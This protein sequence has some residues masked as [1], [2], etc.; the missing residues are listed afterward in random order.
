MEYAF[1]HA[2]QYVLDASASLSSAGVDAIFRL[3][4]S[5]E[6][7]ARGW[8]AEDMTSRALSAVARASATWTKNLRARLAHTEA[9]TYEE[10]GEPGRVLK[11]A[12]IPL[13]AAL[14]AV[15]PNEIAVRMLAA[16]VNPSDLNIIEGKYPVPRELPAVGGNEGVGEVISVGRDAERAFAIGDRVVPN[17]SYAQGTWRREVIDVASSFDVIDRDI[18][19]H[20]AAMLTVNPCTAYRLLEDSDIREGETVVLNAATSG[21]GRALLQIARDRG[22]K[23]IAMCRPRPDEAETEATFEALR[24]AGADVVLPDVEGKMLRLDAKTRELAAKA[25]YGFN[26]VSGYSAQTMLRLL[27]PNASSVMVTY[28]GMSKQPLV[29]PTG[30]FIFKDITLRGFWLTRWLERDAHENAG[31]GRRAM[32]DQVSDLIRRNVVSNPV[33]ALSDVPLRDL[34]TRLLTDNPDAIGRKKLLVRL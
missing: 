3:A 21:V 16:P 6:V 24:A 34:P 12:S 13:R 25:R 9:A 22:I 31:A 5:T 17:R 28:G 8:R 19:V 32:L 14:D 11:I 18:P 27:Q 30:A 7:G 10:R 15:A 23:T 29:V 33:S 4:A 1:S 2:W 20:E 26:A